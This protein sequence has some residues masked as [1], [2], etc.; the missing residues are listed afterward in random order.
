MSWSVSAIGK[1]EAVAKK[2]AEDFANITYCGPEE[3]AIKDAI[4]DCVA[5]ALAS[6]VPNTAVEVHASGSQ[7]GGLQSVRLDIQP[8]YGFVE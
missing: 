5:K 8:K 7:S 4:A 1:P 2:L 3:L 6:T